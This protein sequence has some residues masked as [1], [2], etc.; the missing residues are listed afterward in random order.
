MN[1]NT[2]KNLNNLMKLSDL[3]LIQNS[4][5]SPDRPNGKNSVIILEYRKYQSYKRLNLWLVILTSIL[6]L[7][8][9]L[10]TIYYIS[11]QN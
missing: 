5:T 1:Q 6:V 7:S 11:A 3:E 9:I 4:I 10:Q 2:N 8:S